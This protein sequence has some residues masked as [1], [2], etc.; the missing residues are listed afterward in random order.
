MDDR[1]DWLGAQGKCLLE[2]AHFAGATLG[3]V[4]YALHIY[5]W[6]SR[7]VVCDVYCMVDS[8]ELVAVSVWNRHL[9]CLRNPS[10]LFR[11]SHRLSQ[12]VS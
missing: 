11:R 5:N 6:A 9:T 1:G 12:V 3:L 8:G 2:V 7:I 4:S 10:R